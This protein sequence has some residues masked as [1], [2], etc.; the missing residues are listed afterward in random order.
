MDDPYL[1]TRCENPKTY[2]RK[3]LIEELNNNTEVGI[4]LL[5]NY[6]LLAIDLFDRKTRK[7]E[8]FEK[9]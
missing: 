6:I 8:G 4:R 3:D 1:V 7:I 5:S 2:S 9:V